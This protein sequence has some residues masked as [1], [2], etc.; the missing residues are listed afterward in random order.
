MNFEEDDVLEK[1]YEDEFNSDIIEV[2]HHYTKPLSESVRL[3]KEAATS[4]AEVRSMANFNALSS[5]TFQVKRDLRALKEVI[6][7]FEDADD[8][9]EEL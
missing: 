8:P 3:M 7:A 4:F 5:L 1:P 6:E 2:I 9:E